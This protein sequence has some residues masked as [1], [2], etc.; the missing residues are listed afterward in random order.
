MGK[1]FYRS[2]NTAEKF[3]RSLKENMAVMVYDCETTGLSPEKNHIIQLSA[4]KCFVSEEGFEEME[5]RTWYIC[6]GYALPEKIV[7]LTGI[8][9]EFLSGMPKE[10]EVVHEIA[11]FFEDMAVAGY[12]NIQFDDAFMDAMYTRNGL[13]FQPQ[14]SIDIYQVVKAV[15]LPGETVNYKLGAITKY[16]G[17]SG[18]ISRFHNAEGDTMATLL[19][20]N[21]CIGRC[22][23][24]CRRSARRL[25]RTKVV[26]ISRWENPRSQRQKR[27][28]VETED[29]TLYFDCLSHTWS[30]KEISDMISRYDMEYVIVQVMK[31]TNCHSETALAKWKG[32]IQISKK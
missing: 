23:E 25:I 3:L 5:S 29:T 20:A 8:T 11:G 14:E 19:V 12:N 13:T 4:R 15:I 21:R 16:L 10:A 22:R 28:Y 27:I 7:E 30:T 9:D 32:S 17:L 1:E 18:E 6:P 31:A 2:G 24:K 26:R